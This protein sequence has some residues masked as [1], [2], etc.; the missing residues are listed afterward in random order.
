MNIFWK[1][2][3]FTVMLAAGLF[4]I[5]NQYDALRGRHEAPALV[6]AY[7]VNLEG[8]IA[9]AVS[10]RDT[11]GHVVTLA[12]YIGRPVV[13]TFWEPSCGW[14]RQESPWLSTAQDKYSRQGLKILSV[15]ETDDSSPEEIAKAIVDWKITYPVLVATTQDVER[16]Y[17]VDGFPVTVYINRFGKV[18]VYSTEA[19]NSFSEIE[20]KIKKIL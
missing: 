4:T 20:S 17:G 12:D 5:I 13:L 1:V 18:V 9:P 19:A 15:T 11:D 6:P 2:I 7:S 16:S 10:L 3:L 14:C 8:K